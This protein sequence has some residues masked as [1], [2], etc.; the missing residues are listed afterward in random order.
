MPNDSDDQ[1]YIGIDVD[2]ELSSLLSDLDD[3][4]EEQV[5]ET[6][7]VATPVSAPLEQLSGGAINTV[8]EL[9]LSDPEAPSEQ[10]D[11]PDLPIEPSQ[12]GSDISDIV[13]KFEHD[14]NEVQTNLKGDRKKIDDVIEIL[15]NRVK[16]GSEAETD[17]ISLVKA[18]AVLSDTN[19][20]SVKLLDSR[21]KLLSATKSAI[22][23]TQ[24]NV[25][26]TGTDAE[27]QNILNQPI[28]GS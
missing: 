21:S 23:A 6:P 17:T 12:G 15:L 13:S 22:N 20:H 24:T 10:N 18:L 3:A 5:S 19:G 4:N 8:P 2:D 11:M 7:D 16:H 26:I 25:T 28:E 14:Y 27:L 1:Q 9:E